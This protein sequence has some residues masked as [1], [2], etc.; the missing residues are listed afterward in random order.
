M[1]FAWFLVFA[2]TIG[3]GF[4]GFEKKIED[5]PVLGLG[6]IFEKLKL[7]GSRVKVKFS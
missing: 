5:P 2:R 1:V 3:S 7:V 4:I 6:N